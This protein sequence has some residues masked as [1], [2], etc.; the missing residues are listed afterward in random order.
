VLSF[1]TGPALPGVLSGTGSLTL[2]H[3]GMSPPVTI[4]FTIDQVGFGFTAEGIDGGNAIGF[5]V[6]TDPSG[7]HITVFV[8]TLGPQR[9]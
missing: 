1:G 5:G 6:P 4:A 3:A 8:H 7:T 2:T 9:G